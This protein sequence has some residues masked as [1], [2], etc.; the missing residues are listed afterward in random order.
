M[1]DLEFRV[2][3]AEPLGG[4]LT[5]IMRFRL[6]VSE[7]TG[8]HIDTV[9]L[10]CQIML[11]TRRRNYDAREEEALLDLFGERSRWG[12]TLKTM[13]WTHASVMVPGFEG[14]TTVN[15]DV[16]STLDVSVAAGKYFFGLE[17][18][19]VPLV[20]QFSGTVFTDVGGAL[21]VERIPWSKEA[22]YR[23]PV[24]TWQAMM[25]EHYPEGV[26]ICLRR[27]VFD[28]LYRYKAHSGRP[29]WEQTFA[30]LLDA[31]SETAR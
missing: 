5:P 10:S 23:L 26:W 17:S 25:D 15:V 2:V 21:Q 18:G 8:I 24:V 29:T 28:R 1:P 22:E 16:P 11:E 13:V 31:V 27:D 6:E 7:T 30:D 4:A 19:E 20:F 12:D 9:A 14:T 3:G